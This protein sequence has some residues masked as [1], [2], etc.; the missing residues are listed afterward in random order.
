LLPKVDDFAKN[1]TPTLG[2]EHTP[3]FEENFEAC[4]PTCDLQL[5]LS[6]TQWSTCDEY[7]HATLYCITV[8]DII[9]VLI[10]NSNS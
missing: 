6:T 7:N 9:H 2:I 10:T 5:R 3:L 8:L 1:A 4:Y